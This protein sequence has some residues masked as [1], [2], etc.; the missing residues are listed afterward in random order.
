[1]TPRDLPDRSKAS[2]LHTENEKPEAIHIDII[3]SGL[4]KVK[5][6]EL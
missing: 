6:N 2:S 5:L 1:M 4:M 3:I